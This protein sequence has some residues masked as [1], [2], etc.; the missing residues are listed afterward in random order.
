R[1]DLLEDQLAILHGLWGE[2]DGW[3]FSGHAVA[4]QDALFYPK[5]V[6]VP[7]RPVGANGT[8]RPGIITGGQGAP[9][10]L[11]IAARWSDEF[12][13]SSTGPEQAGA[14]FARLDDA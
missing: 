3:S 7:G 10:A 8:A 4:L 12:N 5:P 2:P 1:A 9:R 6:D 14:T 11:R 13:L